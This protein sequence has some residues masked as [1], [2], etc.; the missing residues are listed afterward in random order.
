MFENLGYSSA[1]RLSKFLFRKTSK[2]ITKNR[3]YLGLK[4]L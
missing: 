3:H 1:G 2:V 4:C